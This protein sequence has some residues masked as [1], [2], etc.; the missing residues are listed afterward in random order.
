[1]P[2]ATEA[3]W[4]GWHGSSATSGDTIVTQELIDALAD[5]RVDVALLPVNGRDA[6]RESRGIVGNMDTA[7]AVELALTIGAAQLVPYH[8]DGFE[9]NTVAPGGVVDVAD[10]R[11][12]VVAPARFVPFELPWN[13]SVGSR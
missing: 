10:A 3:P 6:I 2:T 1:M 12:H 9:G 8:W 13:D 5:L 4:A 11:L 7:E